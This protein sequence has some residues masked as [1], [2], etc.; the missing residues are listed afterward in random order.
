MGSAG[1]E[2]LYRLGRSPKRLAG[3]YLVEPLRLASILLRLKVTGLARR[4]RR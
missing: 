4:Q 2:W 3:R 1:I